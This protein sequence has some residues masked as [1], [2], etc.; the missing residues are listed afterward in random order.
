[1]T[2]RTG[3]GPACRNRIVAALAA[4]ALAAAMLLPAAP[5]EAGWLGRGL[6]VAGAARSFK[7]NFGEMVDLVGDTLGA[8]IQGDFEEVERLS[9]ELG[10][11]PGRIITDAFPVLGIGAAALEKAEGTREWLK[12]APRRVGRFVGDAVADARMA[13]ETGRYEIEAGVLDPKRPLPAVTVSGPS[14]TSRPAP[15]GSS[16]ANAPDPWGQAPEEDEETAAGGADPWGQD[17]KEEETAAGEVDPPGE[18]VGA[19]R[20]GS[21]VATKRLQGEYAAA[22][23][24]FLSAEKGGSDYEA[25]LSAL[26]ER[27]KELLAK[28]V[29]PEEQELT[30]DERRRVQACLAEREFDPGAADG[31][32][33]PRTRT[34]IRAWQATQGREQSGRLDQSSARTLLE[35]CEVVVAEAETTEDDVLSKWPPGKKFRD[36]AECPELVVVPSGEFMMGSPESERDRGDDEGPLRRVTIGEAF[37]VGVYEV[38]FREWDACRRAGGC[39]HAP[40]DGGRGRGDRPVINVSW[41]DAKEYVRWLSGETGFGYRLLSESEWEY[42]ARAGTTGPYHFG[43]TISRE[44]ANFGSRTVPVGSFPANGFGLHDVHGNVWEWVEDCY[45]DSYRGAPSDGSAWTTGGDCDS[46]V[47]RGGSWNFEPEFLRSASRLRGTAGGRGSLIGF[48]VARTLD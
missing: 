36:C 8:A 41:G 26:L 20:E 25:A 46:R 48:R 29:G 43:S 23:D 6:G 1:M 7:R 10:E 31:V 13:L 22:L 16:A 35:E 32:F 19:G 28:V 38:T 12:A 2:R 3:G 39:S 15:S 9:G 42:A 5:A 18:D 11:V 24:R 4:V 27:E 37:A 44:E 40:R 17:P 14:G 34:A 21:D 30:P 47:L 33:G 45:R